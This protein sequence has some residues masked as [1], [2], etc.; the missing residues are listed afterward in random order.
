VTVV[1]GGD[2]ACVKPFGEGDD[3]RV[4]AAER[5]IAVSAGEFSDAGPVDMGERLDDES[6]VDDGGVEGKFRRRAEFR[7]MR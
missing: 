3:T 7:L 4:C 1:E 2:S 5:E 6:V